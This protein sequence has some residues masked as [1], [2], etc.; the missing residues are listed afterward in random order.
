MNINDIMIRDMRMEERRRERDEAIAAYDREIRRRVWRRRIRA[1][2][3]VVGAILF[4]ALLG[5]FCWLC[6][7]AS[8]Y[9]WE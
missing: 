9:H 8:G 6:C 7:A 5:V 2:A 3:E 1:I 4:F